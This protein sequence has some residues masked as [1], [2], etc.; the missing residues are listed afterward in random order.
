[1]SKKR[2]KNRTAHNMILK[3]Q[4]RM[5]IFFVVKALTSSIMFVFGA[6]FSFVS[7]RLDSK[8]EKKSRSKSLAY[9]SSITTDGFESGPGCWHLPPAQLKTRSRSET[10]NW[11]FKKFLC[12]ARQKRTSPRMCV[13]SHMCCFVWRC[14]W[15]AKSIGQVDA[16]PL[17]TFM[18]IMRPNERNAERTGSRRLTPS[19]YRT[20]WLMPRK[21]GRNSR[22]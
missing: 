15:R 16:L 9:W 20:G 6:F 3:F 7:S 2:R 4:S 13:Q 1:M 10:R 22:P 19:P 18:Q 17:C 21:K 8:T 12:F 14:K 11:L 5:L